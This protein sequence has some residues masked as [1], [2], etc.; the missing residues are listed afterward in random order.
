MSIYFWVC[1]LSSIMLLQ[2]TMK[3]QNISFSDSTTDFKRKIALAVETYLK[4]RESCN[5]YAV[6]LGLLAGVEELASE[7]YPLKTFH[8]SNLSYKMNFMSRSRLD[9]L[10]L[11]TKPN[12]NEFFDCDYISVTDKLQADYGLARVSYQSPTEQKYSVKNMVFFSSLPRITE[13]KV[14]LASTVK[15]DVVVFV[16]D[17]LD[18]PV[19]QKNQHNF[20][21]QK[22]T[23]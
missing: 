20:D 22:I 2:E 4:N 18:A 14:H 17:Y 3:E 11:F 5:Q 7:K 1:M 23:N 16:P 19:I 6:Y 12:A 8:E 10:K 9:D 13:A 15:S 21:I